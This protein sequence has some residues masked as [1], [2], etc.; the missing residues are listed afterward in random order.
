MGCNNIER[1]AQVSW[2]RLVKLEKLNKLFAM[3]RRMTAGELPET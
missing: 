2:I 1:I 3:V